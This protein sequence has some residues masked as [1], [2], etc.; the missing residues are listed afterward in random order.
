LSLHAGS[1]NIHKDKEGYSA[2]VDVA[3]AGNG[4]ASIQTTAE[5]PHTLPFPDLLWE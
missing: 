1:E 5:T 3:I 2:C 4:A